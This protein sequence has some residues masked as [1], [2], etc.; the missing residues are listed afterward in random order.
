MEKHR[1]YYGGD[2][3][4]NT[5]EEKSDFD[6]MVES[7]QDELDAEAKAIFSKKVLDECAHPQNIGRMTNPDAVGIITGPCGDT[8]EFFLKIS[9][10]KIIE[11]QFM[12]DGCG[13]TIACGSMLTKMVKGST[14]KDASK[15]T[16]QNLINALD[17]L[18]EE[19]LHCAKL[20]ADTLHK[21]IKSYLD[22]Q[23][24]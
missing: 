7:I 14:F 13:P 24:K 4:N 10:E 11:V 16:N 23:G 18:P 20:A 2:F 17:G 1:K 5:Y 9:D 15:I 3:L 6:K 22:E 19:N 21:A 12:T 8:M